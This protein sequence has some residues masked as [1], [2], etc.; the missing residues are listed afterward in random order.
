MRQLECGTGL[1]L[2]GVSACVSVAA[3][4]LWQDVDR[5]ARRL[6]KQ[7]ESAERQ[8]ERQTSQRTC[9]VHD[10]LAGSS[11]NFIAAASCNVQ[12]GN[13]QR[14]RATCNAP[15]VAAKYFY[16]YFIAPVAAAAIY[17][18]D[19]ARLRPPARRN[20]RTFLPAAAPATPAPGPLRQLSPRCPLW[21]CSP[22][23]V[24]VFSFILS[25]QLGLGPGPAAWARAINSSST[26]EEEGR[27]TA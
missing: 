7:L 17:L 4:W 14:Q 2:I 26:L 24:Y 23:A 8:S 1:H 12:H 11:G 13:V 25:P 6:A 20:Q 15:T 16:L 22:A 21:C 27:G 10:R 19:I 3:R 9:E 5:A 18:P